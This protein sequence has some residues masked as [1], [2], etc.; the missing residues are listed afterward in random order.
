[1]RR[2]RL[3]AL[4]LDG[5][6]GSRCVLQFERRLA[7]EHKVDPALAAAIGRPGSCRGETSRV[8][9][10]RHPL[11]ELTFF[12][13]ESK[14]TGV[15]RWPGGGSWTDILGP[16]LAKQGH[17]DVALPP[18]SD[19]ED[20]SM[21]SG[22]RVISDTPITTEPSSRRRSGKGGTRSHLRGQPIWCL[23]S[24]TCTTGWTTVTHPKCWPR[25]SAR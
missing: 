12:G 13:L 4:L 8:I 19:S 21:R 1:M 3:H 6:A 22:A 16:S 23:L 2:P 25:A 20:A 15:E 10:A 5:H 11:E 18:S 9:K 7:D 24:A 14:Q 17:Y